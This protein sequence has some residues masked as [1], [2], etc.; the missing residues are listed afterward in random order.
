MHLLVRQMDM[1]M[2]ILDPRRRKI[3]N[4]TAR[5]STYNY[6]DSCFQKEKECWSEERKVSV[7]ASKRRKIQNT[8]I[9]TN[10]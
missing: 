1:V 9:G 3:Q 7:L 6:L 8:I 5:T 10:G 2:L 4:F